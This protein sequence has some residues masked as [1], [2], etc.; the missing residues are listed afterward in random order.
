[1]VN[2]IFKEFYVLLVQNMERNQVFEKLSNNFLSLFSI[3]LLYQLDL[4][5]IVRKRTAMMS[6]LHLIFVPMLHTTNKM[7]LQQ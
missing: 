6:N 5:G 4:D 3:F 2:K 7:S 1:M